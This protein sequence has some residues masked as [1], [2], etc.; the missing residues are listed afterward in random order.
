[1]LQPGEDGALA[2]NALAEPSVDPLGARQLQRRGALHDAVGALRDPHRSHAAFGNESLSCHGPMR[3]PAA[4]RRMPAMAC[5]GQCH[6]WPQG[7]AGAVEA[8]STLASASSS[9]SS[10]L[11]VPVDHRPAALPSQRRGL[12]WLQLKRHR[13]AGH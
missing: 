10:A 3:S 7:L 8:P 1:M 5:G 4:S 12:G 11:Q 13:S 6:D 2:R 9:A